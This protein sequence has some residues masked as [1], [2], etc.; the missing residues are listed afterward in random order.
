M[1]RRNRQACRSIVIALVATALLAVPGTPAQALA[2]LVIIAH[3][4]VPVGELEQSDLER[5]Y[6]GKTSRWPDGTRIMPAMLKA[7][8]TQEEFVEDYLDRPLHR[9]ATYWRQMVFTGKGVP[10]RSFVSE[11]TLVDFVTATPGALGFVT[12]RTEA[13]GVKVLRIDD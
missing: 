2:E 4:D 5:I 3:A 9:F 12:S 11:T 13:A 8:D 1:R 7:G 6:L 10:P